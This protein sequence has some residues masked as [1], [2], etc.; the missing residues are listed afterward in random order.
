[1]FLRII[2]RSRRQARL[3]T[4]CLIILNGSELE[5]VDQPAPYTL[6]FAKGRYKNWENFSKFFDLDPIN[7]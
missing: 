4:D 3:G 1:M 7:E 6:K 5:K 2:P